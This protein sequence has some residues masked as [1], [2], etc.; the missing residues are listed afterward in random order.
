MTLLTIT[1]ALAEIKTTQARIAKKR[2]GVHQYLAR[3]DG[4]RDPLEK[5]GGSYAFIQAELQSVADLEARI[6]TLRGAIARKNHEVTIGI[7]GISKSMADWLTWRREIM[8][9]REAFYAKQ[10]ANL[11]SI[12]QQATQKGMAIVGPGQAPSALT[13]LIVNLDEKQ[14]AEEIEKLETIKGQ[15]DGQLSLKNATVTLE[16]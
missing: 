12:R 13:D 15:L 6:V 14:L 5:S 8:P 3:Q 1:E 2:D 16:V 10:R 9:N 7:S 11:A 4:L